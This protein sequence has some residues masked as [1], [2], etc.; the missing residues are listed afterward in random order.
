MRTS[1]CWS[2]L[3]TAACHAAATA[4]SL[5]PYTAGG[6][7]QGRLLDEAGQRIPFAEIVL[8]ETPLKATSDAEGL[9]SL[10]GLSPGDKWLVVRHDSYQPL[11]VPVQVLA[12]KTL[13]LTLRLAPLVEATPL[14]TSSN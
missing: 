13:S 14:P 12:D 1:W 7:I 11:R 2:L 6:S 10:S 9:F 4:P 5:P 8:E 3:V